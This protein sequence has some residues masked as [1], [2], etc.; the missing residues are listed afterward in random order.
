M[1]SLEET[2]M[3]LGLQNATQPTSQHK[4]PQMNVCL[5]VHIITII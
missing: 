5:Q 1:E 2:L 3:E 4:A